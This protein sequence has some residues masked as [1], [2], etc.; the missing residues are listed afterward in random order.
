MG[1]NIGNGYISYAILK[2]LFGAP[3]RLAQ[4]RNAWMDPLPDVL[5]D[6]INND[7]SHVIFVMQDMLR[8]GLRNPPFD[9][10]RITYFLDKIRTPIVP[11]SLGANSTGGYDPGLASRLTA[12]QK[13]FV[14]T[15]A[16]KS[17]SLGVRGPYTAEV[18][19]KLGIWNV[20]II[21]CPSYYAGG[22]LRVVT[23]RP[24][25]PARVVT[26]G[27][28]F[29]INLPRSVHILQDETCLIE[30]LF[31][32]SKGSADLPPEEHRARWDPWWGPEDPSAVEES[33]N[34]FP[35]GRFSLPRSLHLYQKAVL[36][37]LRF[38]PDF[39]AWE[40][41]YDDGDFCLTVGDRLHS[42]ILSCNRGVPAIVTNPDARARETCEFLHIPYRPDLGARSNL[43]AEFEAL[44]LSDLNDSYRAFY[45]GFLRF[46]KGH[47]LEPSAQA[48]ADERFA[49]F[50]VQ[51]TG[52]AV[53]ADQLYG[54]F[55]EL[56]EYVRCLGRWSRESR[57]RCAQL[58]A[59]L[60][61]LL[62]FQQ[63]IAGRIATR[64]Q[65]LGHRHPRAG[66]VAR[67]ILRSLG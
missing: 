10:D 28:F 11:V 17:T 19:A 8:E 58:E 51:E 34:P 54:G 3:V 29:N 13:R 18:L 15:V 63:S 61:E 60:D 24:W 41:L 35:F 23:K 36:G 52:T 50:P 66:S 59:R 25:N 46:M 42:G 53:T 4:V 40:R 21:G 1:W 7:C 49:F 45:E 5:A 9:F 64:L 62:R 55:F 39:C 67:T 65:E 6:E 38:F 57:E 43:A 44:D 30:T 32:H 33:P 56:T 31:V 48:S 20:E 2:V 14:A 47:G 26:T 37:L 22:P 27:A 16:E 12:A